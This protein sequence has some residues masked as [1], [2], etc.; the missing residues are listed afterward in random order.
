MNSYSFLSS[1]CIVKKIY[2]FNNWQIVI[3]LWADSDFEPL[4]TISKNKC[5]VLSM[6]LEEW[7]YLKNNM[8]NYNN[9]FI[10][11]YCVKRC[12]CSFIKEIINMLR[13]YCNCIN[14]HMNFLVSLNEEVKNCISY[15][16]KV[17]TNYKFL[18]LEVIKDILNTNCN[19]D[20]IVENEM[21]AIGFDFFVS[22]YYFQM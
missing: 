8:C 1:V 7:H 15:I 19:K 16:R 9:V 13:L 14:I 20:S 18:S 17:I 4:I 10:Y 2:K 12:N 3:G 21:L 11:L 6:N 5:M 22:D